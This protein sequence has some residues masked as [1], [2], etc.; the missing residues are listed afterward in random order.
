[1]RNTKVYYG[2]RILVGGYLIY[3]A[4][5]L[6]QGLARGDEGNPIVMGVAGVLFLAIGVFLI[7]LGIRGMGRG[8]DQEMENQEPPTLEDSGEEEPE[9]AGLPETEEGEEE[10]REEE[11]EKEQDTDKE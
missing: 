9:K 11:P 1:M 7:I 10:N 8:E 6:L 5:Q 4:V 3:L 2:I